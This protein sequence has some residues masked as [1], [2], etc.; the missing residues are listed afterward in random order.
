[1]RY[2]KPKKSS[3]VYSAPRFD[4]VYIRWINLIPPTLKG[5]GWEMST[6]GKIFSPVSADQV[7]RLSG[8]RLVVWG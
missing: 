8:E 2:H 4:G 1:M 5:G 6:D 7:R 3:A